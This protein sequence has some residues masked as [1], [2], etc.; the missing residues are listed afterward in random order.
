MSVPSDEAGTLQVLMERLVKFRLP[1]AMQI[2]QHADAG[3]VLG[4]AEID[5][6]QRALEDAQDAS[7]LVARHPEVHAIG[8]QVV[9][10]YDEIV[11]KAMENEQRR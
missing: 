1:R 11:R 5:F 7:R 9:E 6:L 3:G 8:A 2:K 10:L 4:D